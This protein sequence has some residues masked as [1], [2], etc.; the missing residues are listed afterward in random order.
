MLTSSVLRPKIVHAL[1]PP[2]TGS[3]ARV[4]EV[5][6]PID[7]SGTRTRRT[8]IMLLSPG[9]QAG[10]STSR[11]RCFL[12]LGMPA[13]TTVGPSPARCVLFA[14]TWSPWHSDSLTTC[15]ACAAATARVFRSTI[16]NNLHRTLHR[17]Y[18]SVL[19]GM[20]TTFTPPRSA[21]GTPMP[22]RRVISSD[23][24]MCPVGSK[25]TVS[26]SRPL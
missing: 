1:Q 4:G 11:S 3:P 2:W 6:T 14:G 17:M 16:F 7:S 10:S 25:E 5:A 22:L 24:S 9:D 20:P 18:A 15:L 21:M 13:E 12:L 19:L 26:C 23:V 8:T